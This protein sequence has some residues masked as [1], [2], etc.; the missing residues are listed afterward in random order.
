MDEQFVTI[1]GE[2]KALGNGRVG[3]YLVRFGTP[4]A[5]DLVGDYFTNAT[6]YDLEADGTGKSTV[7][8][9]HGMDETLKR[10]KLGRA[11]LRTDGIGVWMEAQLAMR[12][13][14][15][16][17]IYGMIEA[18]KMGLSSGTAPH[19]VERKAHDN[20]AYE[21][22][23]WPLGLDA[24]ITP[25]P[26]EPRTSVIPLKAYLER[27][28]PFVKALLPQ[29]AGNASADATKAQPEP[30]PTET[31]SP[32][33]ETM[34]N[35]QIQALIDAAVTKA[36]ETATA[37]AV[38]AYEEKLAAEPPA[39]PMEY[40]TGNGATKSATKSQPAE[41]KAKPEAF[42]SLGEQLD[43]IRRS[44]TPGYSV[45]RRLTE[46]K[47]ISGMSETV[48][49]D[50]G[51]L[52]QTDFASELLRLTH[53]TGLLT[54]RVR[55]IPVG[56]NSNGLKMNAVAETSRATGS[57]WGG[58]R[59]YWREEAGTVTAAAPAFRTMKLELNDLMGLC[60]ATD[61][62]LAD[63]VA[64]GA[65]IQQA[66]SEEFGF[67]LDDAIIRGSGNG[68]PLGIMNSN[69]YVSVAKESGQAADT[70][71]WENINNMW[72][73]LW[74]KSRMNSAWFIHQDVLPQLNAMNMPIGTGGV[75][76]Y[77][78]ATGIAGSPYSTL[79]GRPV[80]EIEQADTVGD[81]GD[82]MLLDL[83]Q[84]LMIDKGGLEAAQ[85]IHVRF[86]YG[87]NTFR[88]T[89]RTD[90]QPIWNSPLTLYNSSTTVAPFVLL[91][92]RA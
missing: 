80:I 66:F 56:A 43:A 64:L 47:A 82:I 58:V 14:Y 91:D 39:N 69:A 21:I 4:D 44:S 15:D 53:E 5:T 89:L 52:V 12:D 85:S 2:L 40:D 57:R 13:E 90:G 46:M 8:Y 36:T 86:I 10:R 84:Y 67:L 54:G 31:K 55:R 73:R 78:P 6:D 88:F 71:M 62:L 74:S 9:H 7:L 48:P 16:Q 45:D 17:A 23:R 11:D 22:T 87:E 68:Q 27:A 70:V 35:E 49:E 60:Y 81:Q 72:A 25:I 30:E 42:K 92:E 3:G 19:L 20:G 76:V 75:P 50:G 77:L 32:E 24:S 26:A 1:G 59:A 63:S 51:Y 28:E 65:V 79:F 29:D 61:Q 33:S 34:D 37:A 41:V 38:K 83:S 18:G